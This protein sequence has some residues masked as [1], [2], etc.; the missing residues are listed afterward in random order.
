MKDGLYELL[1]K[2]KDN[3]ALQQEILDTKKA[4]DPAAAL[5]QLST[6]ADCPFTVGELYQQGEWYLAQLSESRLGVTEP[7]AMWGDVLDEFYDSIEGLNL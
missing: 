4:K 5:C 1:E 6:K 2:A 7:K 3:K